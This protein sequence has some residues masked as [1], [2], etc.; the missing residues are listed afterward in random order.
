MSQ[1]IAALVPKYQCVN[2]FAIIYMKT[3]VHFK[4]V[5]PYLLI[6]ST[7]GTAQITA[8]QI[9]WDLLH[10]LVYLQCAVSVMY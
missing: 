3:V 1:S 7:V 5:Q 4:P 8:L 6:L 10:T 9:L 2:Q